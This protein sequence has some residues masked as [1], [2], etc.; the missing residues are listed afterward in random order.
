MSV[1]ILTIAALYF[2][3]TLIARRKRHRNTVAIFALNLLAGWT[4]L[5]WIVSI[6]WALTKPPRVIVG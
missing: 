2:L 1:F 6:V 3:P 4:A 5:G